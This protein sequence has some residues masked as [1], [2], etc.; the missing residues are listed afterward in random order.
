MIVHYTLHI[1]HYTLHSIQLGILVTPQNEKTFNFQYI[2]LL[3]TWVQE[4]LEDDKM[5]PDK[6][7]VAFPKVSCHGNIMVTY[8]PS[9]HVYTQMRNIS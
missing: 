3:M 7:G 9:L 1:I 4:Q 8:P 6:I 2:D 5:F